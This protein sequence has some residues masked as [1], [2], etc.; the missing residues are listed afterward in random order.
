MNNGVN[1]TIISRP[2]YITFEYPFCHEEVEVNFDE[3][4]FKTD[5]WGDGAWCDCPECGKEVELD[6]YEYD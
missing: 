1:Y 6:D 2:S 4:D 5:Y 3:V